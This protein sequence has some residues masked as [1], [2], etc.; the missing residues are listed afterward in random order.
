MHARHVQ[1]DVVL[2]CPHRI[3]N[4][5]AHMVRPARIKPPRKQQLQPF[6]F[7]SLR[8]FHQQPSRLITSSLRQLP[9]SPPPP[10]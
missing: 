1:Y 9:P 2:A 3:L 7:M 8:N 10:H 5:V 6:A 4:R